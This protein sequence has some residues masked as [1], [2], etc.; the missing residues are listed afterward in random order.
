MSI[1]LRNGQELRPLGVLGI[2]KVVHGV[3]RDALSFVFA[4]DVSMDAL[5]ELFNEEN[6]ESIVIIEGDVSY[7]H[8]GYTVRAEIRREPQLVEAATVS[9]QAVYSDRIFV[10]MAQRT[11]EE[12]RIKDMQAQI[13]ELTAAG[14]VDPIIAEKAAAYDIITGGAE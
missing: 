9:S 12:S 7:E 13:D 10:T 5:A 3:T 4:D 11:Y 6:C 8:F 1:L 14:T 2:K